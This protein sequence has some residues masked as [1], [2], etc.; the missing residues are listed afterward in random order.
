MALFQAC[1]LQGHDNMEDVNGF[2]CNWSG[3][4]KPASYV[5]NLSGEKSDA[6]AIFVPTGDYSFPVADS[7]GGAMWTKFDRKSA[8][9]QNGGRGVPQYSGAE[10][11][12]RR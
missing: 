10:G 4:P 12:S 7:S 5:H 6:E 11:H 8:E 2:E 1:S 3:L 9:S